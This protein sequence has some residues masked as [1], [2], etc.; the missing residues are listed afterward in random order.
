M[1][2]KAGLSGI[3]EQVQEYPLANHLNWVYRRRPSDTLAAREGVPN[4]SIGK[5]NE[6]D[7]WDQLWQRMDVIYREF[8]L[9]NG[10]ADRL[11]CLVR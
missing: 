4:I 11:W 9:E 8:L 1:L 7:S 2:H 3:V 10:Y 5:N 6:I